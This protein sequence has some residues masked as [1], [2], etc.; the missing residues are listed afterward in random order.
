LIGAVNRRRNRI[1][2]LPV[3]DEPNNHPMDRENAMLVRKAAYPVVLA[4]VLASTAAAAAPIATLTRTGVPLVETVQFRGGNWH[5]HPLMYGGNWREHQRQ[6]D[7]IEG[8]GANARSV[9]CAR[10]RSYDR[11]SH[12]YVNRNGRRVAC[13]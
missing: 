10:F 12:T 6:W 2:I 7:A 9:S 4:M 11:A 3:R 5:D 8:R 1:A 13:P